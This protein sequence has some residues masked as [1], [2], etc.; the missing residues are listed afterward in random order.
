MI[1]I[2]LTSPKVMVYWS[3]VW[4]NKQFFNVNFSVWVNFV[5]T[6]SKVDIFYK[7]ALLSV[8]EQKISRL[9]H[10][11]SWSMDFILSGLDLSCTNAHGME[12]KL[13]DIRSRNCFRL[14]QKLFFQL[15]IQDQYPEHFY[16]R[17]KQSKWNFTCLSHRTSG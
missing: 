16:Y 4:N 11:W 6:R 5:G 13:I 8:S 2:K 14:H 9:S 7:V 3:W 12:C 17:A 1:I 15:L 10:L